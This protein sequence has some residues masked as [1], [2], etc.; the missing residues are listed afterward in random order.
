MN[1]KHWGKA[2]DGSDILAVT[3]GS[4][5]LQATVISFGASLQDLRLR[6]I[7]YPLVL[8]Y[9]DVQGYLT[10]PA[11][12]G[13]VVGRNANRIANAKCKLNGAQLKLTKAEG[14]QHQLHGG[15]QG[16]SFRNWT[17]VL[18]RANKL[19]LRDQLPHGHMGFPGNLSVQITYRIEANVLDVK[20]EAQTDQVTLCNF[21]LHNYF[22]LDNS[23]T[24]EDHHLGVYSEDYLPTDD[25]GIP[26]GKKASVANSAYDYQQLRNLNSLPDGPSLD[27]NFC[28]E[29][30]NEKLQTMA[31]LS[32][33]SSGICLTLESNAVGLQVY[34]AAHMDVYSHRTVHAKPYT[35]YSALALEPQGW[36]NAA[37][38]SA[39]PSVVLTPG[40]PYMQ[41]T[42]FSFS[43]T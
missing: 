18:A 3:I 14:Q 4:D 22:N 23:L 9:E 5:Q 13:A 28:F 15:P 42:R 37:N 30:G 2:S 8:G 19:V 35:A 29:G 34:D 39:F 27:H 6:N 32:S 31:T 20:I 17:L 1:I 36:P 12:L 11:Y 38:E 10:N 16:S 33:K 21:T 40:Q 25:T 41:H 24:L 26:L 7:D 43:Q